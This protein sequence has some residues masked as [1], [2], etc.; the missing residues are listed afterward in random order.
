MDA[1]IKLAPNNFNR[2]V[3]SGAMV[4]TLKNVDGPNTQGKP[5]GEMVEIDWQTTRDLLVENADLDPKVDLASAWTNAY[6]PR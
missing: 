4:A 5:W 2:E 3:I 1:Q 6:L